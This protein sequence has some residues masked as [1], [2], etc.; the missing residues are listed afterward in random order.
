MRFHLDGL[1]VFFPYD[2]I[3][4]EQLNYMRE[5]KQAIDNKGE[6]CAR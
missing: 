4:P 1:E 2:Y 3:Y 5:L 6:L